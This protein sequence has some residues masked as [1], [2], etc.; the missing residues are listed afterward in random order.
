MMGL[1]YT[2]FMNLASYLYELRVSISLKS[3]EQK[4]S[5]G[6]EFIS[7]EVL[8]YYLLSELRY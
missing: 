2:K 1:I 3:I 8:R 6:M 4:I 5:P 7:T